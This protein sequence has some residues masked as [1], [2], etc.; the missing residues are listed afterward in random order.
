MSTLIGVVFG[1]ALMMSL[2]LRY[3]DDFFKALAWFCVIVFG[4]FGLLKAYGFS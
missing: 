1:W 3:P 2:L 4:G